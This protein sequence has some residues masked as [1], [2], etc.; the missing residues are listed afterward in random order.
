MFA[1]SS[2]CQLSTSCL[3]ASSE[4]T[5][6]CCSN[7]CNCAHAAAAQGQSTIMFFKANVLGN[8]AGCG[9]VVALQVGCCGVV[10]LV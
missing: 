3:T 5:L 2:E 9:G 6:P 4:A 7:R 8:S 10:V 1:A